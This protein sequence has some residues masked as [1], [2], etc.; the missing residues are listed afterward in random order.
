MSSVIH[1]LK[2]GKLQVAKLILE[3]VY[4]M[5]YYT[6]V[7][8]EL[9]LAIESIDNADRMLQKMIKDTLTSKKSKKA[10]KK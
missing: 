6:T 2:R 10:G 4:R 3:E 7:S 5:Y 8:I 1:C 9:G